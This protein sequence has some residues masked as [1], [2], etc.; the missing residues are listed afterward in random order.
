VLLTGTHLM[1]TGEVLA[2][3]PTLLAAAPAL[4]YLRELIAAKAGAE[5]SALATVS[6]APTAERL[7]SDVAGL[8]AAL[9][10]ARGASSLP[11]RPSTEA[12]LHDLVIRCRLGL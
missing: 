7:E 2:D 3:L 9:E 10:E 11:D 12:A 4:G 5:H 1:R 6:G 8:H